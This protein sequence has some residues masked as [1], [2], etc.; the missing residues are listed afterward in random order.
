[1]LIRKTE[2]LPL[3]K[4]WL[5]EVQPVRHF[6]VLCENC[7]NRQCQM[8]NAAVNEALNE[9]LIDEEDFNG[10][11]DSI[12]TFDNFDNLELA[13]SCEKVGMFGM[14]GCARLLIVHSA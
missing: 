1:M 14:R 6:V 11:R 5:V 9:V 12:D 13:I 7:A 3:I 4:A 2:N 10:L 8:N